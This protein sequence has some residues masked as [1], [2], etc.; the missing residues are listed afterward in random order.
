MAARS[1]RSGSSTP[2]PFS[3]SRRSSFFWRR[4]RPTRPGRS[5]FSWRSSRPRPRRCSTRSWV[6]SCLLTSF[7]SRRSWPDSRARNEMNA[8]Q[9]L[10][11]TLELVAE[12]RG[13]LWAQYEPD[14]IVRELQAAL[15]ALAAGADV[16]VPRLRLLFAPTGAIQEISLDNGWG[17]EFLVLSGVVD[18]FL[19]GRP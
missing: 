16:D 2:R 11:R 7:S 19:A 3:C 10:Q 14:E 9:A 17:D 12:S 18:A 4:G 8:G 1:R 6:P 13:S 15:D 5:S